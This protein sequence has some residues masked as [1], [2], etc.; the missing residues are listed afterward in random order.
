MKLFASILA[1]LVAVSLLSGCNSGDA[2]GSPAQ[3]PSVNPPSGSTSSTTNP[4]PTGTGTGTGTTSTN[5]V[6]ETC[7][8]GDANK[9]CLGIHFVTYKDSSGTAT[10][11]TD[12]AATIIHEMNQIWAQCDI[13]FQIEKYEAVDPTQY[14]LSY[15]AQSQNELDQIR[16]A[17]SSP[18]DELLAVTTGPWGTTVNAW[19]NMPG[20]GTYGAIMEASIVTYGNGIIYAHEFGHYLGLDHVSDTSDLMNPVIYTTS[21][22]L[23]SGQC[24]TAQQTA[25]QYWAGMLRK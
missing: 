5:T 23:D 20:S 16:T 14:S 11:T 4:A 1:P 21:A 13:G 24:Q 22:K 9:I 8:G 25:N 2:A 12:Q 17:F 6:G 3:T 15:G 19:T 10:A 18:A 7:T